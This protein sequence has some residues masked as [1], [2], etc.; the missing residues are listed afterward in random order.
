MTSCN[1][2]APAKPAGLLPTFTRPVRKRNHFGGIAVKLYPEGDTLTP[3]YPR[4]RLKLQ[5]PEP[6]PVAMEQDPV[7]A[8]HPVETGAPSARTSQ[9]K[10]RPPRVKKLAGF[11]G[12]SVVPE[13]PEPRPAAQLQLQLAPKPAASLELVPV[14]T[15]CVVAPECP[16]S[17]NPLLSSLPLSSLVEDVRLLQRDKNTGYWKTD[18]FFPGQEGRSI[19]DPLDYD[20]VRAVLNYN[21]LS[22]RCSKG[23]CCAQLLELDVFEVRQRFNNGSL[24]ASASDAA[25]LKKVVDDARDER[26]KGGYG[27]V[28]LNL[29]NGVPVDV[30]L[31]AFALIAGYTGR[32]LKTAL[33][34]DSISVCA[35]EPVLTSR[36]REVEAV[37]MVRS[38]IHNV[39]VAAHEQQPVASLG[40]ATGK[41]TVLN[42]QVW[43][44]KIKN[45]AIWFKERNKE[46][47]NVSPKQ[48]KKLWKEETQLKERKASSHSKCNVCANIDRLFAKLQGWCTGESVKQRKGLFAARALHEKNHL[49][50]RSEMDYACLR[51]ITSPMTI[52]VIM[53][54][55]ATQRNF[56]LPRLL[57]RRA[58][59]LN[60]IPF[61]GLKLMA[62]YAPG[63]GFTPFLVQD[64]SKTGAN[65]MWTVVWLT[66]TAM[67]AHYGYLP[68]EL[69]LQLDNTSGENKN[70]T[71]LLIAA[72]LQSIGYFKRVRVFFLMVGH[73]HVIIDQIFGVITK[74]I[75]GRELLNVPALCNAIDSVM[76]KNPQYEAKQTSMLH[77][78]F[79]FKTFVPSEE[80]TRRPHTSPATLCSGTTRGPGTAST[81]SCS[82]AGPCACG[83]QVKPPTSMRSRRSSTHLRKVRCRSWRS[84][85]GG[86]SGQRRTGRTFGTRSGSA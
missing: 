61:F 11:E 38:Y 29:R 60:N 16:L 74:Y 40:S 49:G 31:P 6:E 82:R 41:E 56:E 86:T 66:I 79:D 65:L 54:D 43:D 28:K 9:S 72:W 5:T 67:Q 17:S 26:A 45:M 32:A 75:K 4:V 84:A 42:K 30:C 2:P 1:C 59:E 80:C 71:M 39:L 48:F 22:P 69:H 33:A 50:E 15:P 27:T 46:P 58:K 57:K 55:A 18:L 47:P 19:K 70:E 12:M 13:F 20:S 83:S 24:L 51:A 23:N 81:T 7:P 25:K 53:A 77:A 3:S 44:Q 36:E 10:Q 62:T 52:W 63:Y 14:P 68:D 8:S 34:S 21:C 73:T 64:A 35:A 85:K 37:S 78:L 76:V